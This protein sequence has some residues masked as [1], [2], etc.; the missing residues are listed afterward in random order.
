MF[1]I[2][3][4]PNGE[5]PFYFT[6]TGMGYTTLGQYC[7]NGGMPAFLCQP[8]ATGDWQGALV[9]ISTRKGHTCK[10]YDLPGKVTWRELLESLH[11]HH[12]T[13]TLYDPDDDDNDRPEGYWEYFKVGIS[14]LYSQLG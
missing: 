8:I 12:P 14:L 10:A 9:S 2:E 1:T 13:G 3:N 11:E 6:G 7:A 4:S 5:F